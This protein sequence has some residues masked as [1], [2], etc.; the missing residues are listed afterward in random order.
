[1][2]LINKYIIDFN[3]NLMKE[4]KEKGH[5]ELYMM[6]DTQSL[7]PDDASQYR[8]KTYLHTLNGRAMVD[9]GDGEV[10]VNSS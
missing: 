7:K 3:L 10:E 8:D 5:K 1:M 6:D 2:N 4:F 9:C